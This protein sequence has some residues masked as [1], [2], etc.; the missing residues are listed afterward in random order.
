MAISW[1]SKVDYGFSITSSHPNNPSSLALH[2][3]LNNQV[4]PKYEPFVG[5]SNIH[6]VAPK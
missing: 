3:V 5:Q 6:K 4:H 2:E 1:S